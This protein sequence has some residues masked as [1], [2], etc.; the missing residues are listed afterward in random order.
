M[1]PTAF[2]VVVEL[3]CFRERRVFDSG[4]RVQWFCGR[5]GL[6]KRAENADFRE[7]VQPAGGLRLFPAVVDRDG[8]RLELQPADR[9]RFMASVVGNHHVRFKLRATGP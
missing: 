9:E 4:Q 8:V 3:W 6:A 1:E 7:L 2:D 5:G